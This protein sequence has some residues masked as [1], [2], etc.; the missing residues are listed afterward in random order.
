MFEITGYAFPNDVHIHWSLM[1]VMYPYITGFVAGAF[2]VTSLYHLFDRKEF[3]PVARLAMATS[4]CFLAVATFPLLLHLG[5]PERGVNVVITPN[6]AS[7]MAGFGLL[8]TSYLIVLTLE[9]WFVHRFQIIEAA[10]R[11]RGL[12]RLMYKVLALAPTTRARKRWPSITA[13]SRCCAALASRPRASCTGMSGSSSGRS[14]PT[15]GGPRR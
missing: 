14:R 10:R 8:Y 13:P 6:F 2:I 7:A 11:S 12:K 4:F 1:I 5:H 3:K 9:I 15:R